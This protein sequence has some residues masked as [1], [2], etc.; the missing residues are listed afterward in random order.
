MPI[1]GTR[2][3]VMGMKMSQWMVLLVVAL[4]LSGCG[5]QVEINDV[6]DAVAGV[7]AP[8]GPSTVEPLTEVVTAPTV[9]PVSSPA[10]VVNPGGPAIPAAQPVV[11]PV[12]EPDSV[13]AAVSG[14][15]IGVRLSNPV[16]LNG[17][18]GL[19]VVVPVLRS[20]DGTL[21][22]ME[23][24]D[25]R[26][27]WTA[28]L[29]LNAL[30]EW[31]GRI[32]WRTSVGNE[33]I[34][35]L[36]AQILVQ[37]NSTNVL[38]ITPTGYDRGADSD[39][40]GV[41]NLTE[42]VIGTSP[43]NVTDA[44][45]DF[46]SAAVRIPRVAP[47][48]VP[49]INGDAGD[50]VPNTTRFVGEWGSAVSTDVNGNRLSIGNLMHTSPGVTVG[51]ENHHWLAVHDGTW[52]FVLVIV[53]DAGL[54]HFDSQEAAKSWRDDSMEV[55]IDGDNSRSPMY[56]NVDDFSAHLILL[57]SIEGG[58]NSSSNEFPKVF[59]AQNSVPLP[60]S[61]VFTTGPSNGPNAP[62]G[63]SSNGAPQ[64]VYEFA[65]RLSD[66]NIEMARTFGFEL[67]FSDDDDAGDRDA[68]WGWAHPTGNTIDNDF[69]WRDPRFMGRAVL[70]P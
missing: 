12:V 54:H 49:T 19:G 43:L 67:Q 7:D 42:L 20:A 1:A 28:T 36:S 52:L 17:T 8:N 47:N 33:R 57:D 6:T 69:T 9:V 65:I 10:V 32:L 2:Q 31:R 45:S 41:N 26:G 23:C 58:V 68:K 18:L 39:G 66:I 44:S 56:D 35:V 15:E 16:T 25:D 34:E 24:C 22:N 59:R 37:G 61:L 51:A 48:Q 38:D 14:G 62:D 70:L 50:Y 64:D 13:P 4:T 5:R 21:F 55:F 60:P 63:S 30:S 53:D 3:K 27:G 40:D 11:V 29:P 46:L